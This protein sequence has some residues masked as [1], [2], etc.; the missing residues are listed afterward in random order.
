MCWDVSSDGAS[1]TELDCANFPALTRAHVVGGEYSGTGITN[2]E[3][4]V[5]SVDVAAAP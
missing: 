4:F 3:L 2:A 5:D 1:F